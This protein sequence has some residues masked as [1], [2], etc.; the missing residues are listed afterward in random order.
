MTNKQ[1]SFEE[2]T[3]IENNIL[4]SRLKAIRAVVNHSGEKGRALE[5]TVSSFLR[6]ILPREYGVSTGFIAYSTDEGVKLS[7]QLDIIIY[8][9]LR[10]APIVSLESCDIFPIEYVYAYVEVKTSVKSSSDDAGKLSDNSIERCLEINKQLREINERHFWV[11]APDTTTGAIP[12]CVKDIAIRSFL[13]SFT[14][15]GTT[16]R[17]PKKLSHRISEFSKQTGHPVH[18]HG[19][20]IADLGFFQTIPLEPGEPENLHFRVRYTINNP[21]IRFKVE[22][23]SSLCRFQR[24]PENEDWVPALDLYYGSFNEWIKTDN[25]STSNHHFK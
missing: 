6:S 18:F 9:A 20:F 10:G 5:N 7:S 24:I 17:D 13:F 1:I 15:E 16:A 22:L 2:F 25:I 23:I 8:D 14:S 19:I 21:L 12:H 4:C 3:E 11:P